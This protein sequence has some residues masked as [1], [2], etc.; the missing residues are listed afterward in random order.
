MAPSNISYMLVTDDTS[1]KPSEEKC[2][3][4]LIMKY[5]CDQEILYNFVL[6]YLD[7]LVIA[8]IIIYHY[9]YIAR[10]PFSRSLSESAF[11]RAHINRIYYKSTRRYYYQYYSFTNSHPPCLQI[12]LL[13]LV[14]FLT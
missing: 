9:Y 3:F 11:G 14:L 13:L 1:H 10:P 7:D 12:F 4:D 6:R 8:D 2:V 5:P